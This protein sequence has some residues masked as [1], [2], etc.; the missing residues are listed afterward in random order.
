MCTFC[1]SLAIACIIL[2]SSLFQSRHSLYHIAFIAR[3]PMRI[4]PPLLR[5]FHSSLTSL[6]PVLSVARHHRLAGAPPGC[7]TRCRHRFHAQEHAAPDPPVGGPLECCTSRAMAAALQ[8][9]PASADKRPALLV[10]NISF[11]PKHIRDG[12][13][14]RQ[15]AHI[16][17]QL[18]LNCG[19]GRKLQRHDLS[20]RLRKPHRSAHLPKFS[21]ERF[22]LVV[23]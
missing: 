8:A 3:S 7:F 18:S 21:C 9:I 13:A 20:V 11:L 22:V 19:G 6:P 1:F 10:L 23:V 14:D 16:H 17:I 12:K 2:P 15:E 5:T 4:S